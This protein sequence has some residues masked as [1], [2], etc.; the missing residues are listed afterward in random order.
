MA[1]RMV[2]ASS[3]RSLVLLAMGSFTSTPFW[4]IGVMTMKMMRRT[5]MMSAMGVTLMS[6]MAPPFLSPTAIDIGT[7]LARARVAPGPRAPGGL[8]SLLDEVVEQL[9]A[10]VV[11]L[12][13]EAL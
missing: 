4:S 8:R 6:A 7:L 9:R 10:G 2:L 1:T 12:H 11:H 3:F 13:V 5:I